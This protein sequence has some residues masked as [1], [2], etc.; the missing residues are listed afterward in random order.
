MQYGPVWVVIQ[1]FPR[2]RLE[3]WAASTNSTFM[4][5]CE[6]PTAEWGWDDSQSDEVGVK[7][8]TDGGC[9]EVYPLCGGAIAQLFRPLASVGRL[10]GPLVYRYST[11]RSASWVC[12]RL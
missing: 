9:C 5:R 7:R 3:P 12:E 1:A 10:S 6:D 2:S 4:R 8:R 11:Y